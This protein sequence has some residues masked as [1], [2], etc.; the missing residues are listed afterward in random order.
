MGRTLGAGRKK[1]KETR[2]KKQG[3]EK[4]RGSGVHVT[5]I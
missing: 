5:V 3:S 2:G 1:K 4:E